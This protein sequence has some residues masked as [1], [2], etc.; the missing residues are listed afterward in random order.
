MISINVKAWAGSPRAKIPSRRFVLVLDPSGKLGD[1]DEEDDEIA[2]EGAGLDLGW[3][4]KL[5]TWSFILSP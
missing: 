5:G 3:I 1:G 2:D 4:L